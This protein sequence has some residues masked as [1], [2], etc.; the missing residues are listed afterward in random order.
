[1]L[2]VL[3][4]QVISILQDF[5][6][7]LRDHLTLAL[8]KL[9]LPCPGTETSENRL[10]RSRYGDSLFQILLWCQG[11]SN[12]SRFLLAEGLREHAPILSVLAACFQVS[13][14]EDIYLLEE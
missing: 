2:L 6:P 5:S 7:V 13:I 11:N 8:E 4:S 9:P 3:F 1:M 10:F 14:D 12:P